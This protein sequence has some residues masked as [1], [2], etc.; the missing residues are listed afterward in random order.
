MESH[1]GV[2]TRRKAENHETE[3]EWSISVSLSPSLFS[4]LRRVKTLPW[5]DMELHPYNPYNVILPHFANFRPFFFAVHHWLVF[6]PFVKKELIILV[7]Y[8]I[9]EK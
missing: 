9:Q 1:A 7:F 3:R 2:F 4:A 6:L 5:T 8:S